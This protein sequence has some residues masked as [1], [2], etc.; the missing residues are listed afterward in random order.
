[1]FSKLKKII[2][3]LALAAIIFLLW[4]LPDSLTI[5]PDIEPVKI[6]DRSGKL[7]Y[8]YRGDMPGTQISIPFGEIPKDIINVAVAVE[9][10]SFFSHIG[11]SPKA[12]IRAAVQNTK[13]GRIVS[14][15]STITQQ[16]VRNRLRPEKRDYLYKAKEALLAIKLE[17]RMSKEEIMEAYL[18]SVYFGRQA[19]G[20]QAGA[21]TV[22]GKNISEL[23]LAEDAFLM[24]LVQSPSS[25]NPFKNFDLAKKRQKTVLTAMKDS[26]LF[27]QERLDGLEDEPIRLGHGKVE[28]KAPHF[29]FW[30]LDK[31][32]EQI[33]NQKKVLT[34][35]D[36]D[37]QSEVELIISR[38]L[39]KLADKN[40]TSAS[41]V[42]LDAKTGDI[43]AMVGSA[44]YFDQEHDGA[45]NVALSARQPGSALKP[46]TYALA[47]KG[48]AT[49]ATTVAD[50]ETRF[51]TQQG[52]PYVPRNY[53]YGYHGLV[54]YREALANSYNISA[55]KVLER[56]GTAN[57]L[58]FLKVAGLST[59]TRPPEYYGLALTL[60][61]G[62]VKLLDLASAYGMFAR[63]GIT[64][65]PRTLLNEPVY[66][67]QRILDKKISWLI[68]DILDDDI[69]RIPEF[70]ENGPL[71]FNFPV[72]AKTGTTRNSRDNWTIG[73]TPD[74]IVGVWVGN[75]DNTAMLNTSGVT[76]A[77][78]IF[79]DVMLEAVKGRPEADFKK[80]QGIERQEICTLSGK[81]PTP[82]CPLTIS[83]WFITGTEPREVDDIYR[84]FQ[85]DSRNGLL[86]GGDCPAEYVKSAIYAVFPPELKT[87]SRENG[88]P[89]PPASNSPL[90]GGSDSATEG[91]SWI[92][93]KKPAPRDSFRLDPMV[94]DSDEKIIFQ[95]DAGPAIK[96]LDWYVNNEFVA[97]ASPPAFRYE[98]QPITGMFKITAK[99]GK[100]EE[101]VQIEII[102]R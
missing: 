5:T 4:P 14:G 51:F 15:G 75:A 39:E 71:E 79:H 8:E 84:E 26:E 78:P 11:V 81:L 28:I 64:L 43:L 86:A 62:E 32:G 13:L 55:V 95:A 54:R 3:G 33:K 38:Q 45:V 82:L 88:W 80:P 66:T 63:G 24:G 23:S 60:G 46:F 69:A 20:I 6:L 97:S 7:L 101:S 49:S 77:G 18:N 53:D 96:N 91:D 58:E 9:D 56:V 36:L 42:V 72:A 31:Y 30:I 83:E 93:I 100:S 25:Y 2:I 85:I 73:Y 74:V 29:V 1:M 89:T 16:L 12:M 17:T 50:I 41:V 87:W 10:R 27:P 35:L 57:L 92:L 70:G 90:C 19:Y 61:S 52:N 76:G 94:P 34:T 99:S 48:G 65:Q 22:F 102:D 37:L 47:L 40:V 67:G 21:L 44:D 98:W 59:F 68:T